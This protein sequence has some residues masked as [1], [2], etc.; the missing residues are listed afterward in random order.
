MWGGWNEGGDGVERWCGGGVL[1]GI[2]GCAIHI[3]FRYY[4]I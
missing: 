2:D 3:L 1:E 4:D